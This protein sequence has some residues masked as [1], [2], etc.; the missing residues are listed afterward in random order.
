MQGIYNCIPETNHVPTVYSVAAVLYLQSVLHV[1]LFRVLHMFCTCTLALSAVCVQCPVRLFF[2]STLVSDFPFMF[3]RYCL[4]DFEMLPV[5]PVIAGVT[6]VSAFHMRCFS[7]VRYLLSLSSSSSS[8]L[9]RVFTL[10]FLRKST[11]LGNTVL[12]LFCCYYSWCLYRW[13]QC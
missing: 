7:T 11:S 5:A 4:S 8:P 13:F 12:Q 9:C 1:M 6:F 3:L 2:C 10:I